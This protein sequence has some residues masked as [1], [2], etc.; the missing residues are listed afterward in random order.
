MTVNEIVEG[1]NLSVFGGKKGLSREV[2][3]GIF[4]IC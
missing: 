2:T 1:L 3:G 4:P